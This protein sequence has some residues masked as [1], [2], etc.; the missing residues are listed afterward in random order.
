MKEYEVVVVSALIE[1]KARLAEAKVALKKN[2][3]E[4]KARLDQELERIKARRVKIEEDEQSSALHEIDQEFEQKNEKLVAQKKLL[5]E[6]NRQIT[7]IQRK[8]E[9]CPSN[10]EIT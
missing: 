4:E 6:Q 5:A 7:I 10:I 1:E 9:S 2:C 3:R 8:I